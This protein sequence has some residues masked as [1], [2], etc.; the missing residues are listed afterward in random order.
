MARLQF[1]RQPFSFREGRYSLLFTGLGFRRG[2]LVN[3]TAGLSS[4]GR[5]GGSLLVSYFEVV[6]RFGE[7]P[8]GWSVRRACLYS[9]RRKSSILGSYPNAQP[10]TYYSYLR[11]LHTVHMHTFSDELPFP[12]F[13]LALVLVA[14]HPLSP[15]T[16][17]VVVYKQAF[18][19]LLHRY[20]FVGCGCCR[21][22]NISWLFAFHTHHSSPSTFSILRQTKMSPITPSDTTSPPPLLLLLNPKIISRNLFRV[23]SLSTFYLNIVSE[24]L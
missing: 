13:H 22:S 2:S 14:V 15:S 18:E 10:Y 1:A 17:P 11:L 8:S 19:L 7:G 24:L 12:S 20:S 16:P 21:R 6:L 3:Y 5:G 4:M 9:L 23:Q